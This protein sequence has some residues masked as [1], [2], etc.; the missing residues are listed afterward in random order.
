MSEPKVI[1][2]KEYCTRTFGS[3][4]TRCIAACPAQ[5][6]STDKD[7]D[8]KIVV[9][10]DACTQ[11]AICCGVCDALS[12]TRVTMLDLHERVR[13]I[14]QNG[15]VVVFTCKENV[16]PDLDLAK[17]VIVM[18]CIASISPELWT[19]ILSE[20]ITVRVAIDMNYCT[21]CKRGGSMGMP[22]YTYA[23]EQAQRWAASEIRFVDIIPEKPTLR[24]VLSDDTGIN[25]RS[26][27][28]GLAVNIVDA[29]TGRRRKRNSNAIEQIRNARETARARARLSV[30]ETI[31]ASL[32]ANEAMRTRIIVPKREMLIDAINND[33][34]IA[35][36][37]LVVVSATNMMECI[38]CGKCCK[39]CPTAARRIDADT[40]QLDYDR[41]YC[42][43]CGLC[44]NACP[45]EIVTLESLKADAFNLD[46]YAGLISESP[47]EIN[48]EPQ[49]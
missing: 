21:D 7:D 15:N 27:I 28:S 18:P 5:A 20:K 44:V 42:I 17:N 48:P 10:A 30:D 1:F 36:R 43:G 34:K 35:P 38:D 40:G 3:T 12:S 11:C 23:I 46:E 2:L 49:A 16:F 6:L 24:R 29:A 45:Q 31:Q 9:D 4:C 33:P 47:E 25:R 19:L 39:N 32:A 26:A 41:L 8:T 13:S 22:L 14:A 37:V